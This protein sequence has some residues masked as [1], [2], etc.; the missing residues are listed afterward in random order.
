MKTMKQLLFIVGIVMTFTVI[1][2]GEDEKEEN[3]D[4]KVKEFAVVEC[5]YQ[6]A[7]YQVTKQ[8]VNAD[9]ALKTKKSNLMKQASDLNSKYSKEMSPEDYNKFLEKVDKYKNKHCK[10]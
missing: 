1:A 9:E 8:G 4:P 3:V 10:N 2:C 5:E 6:E 7:V